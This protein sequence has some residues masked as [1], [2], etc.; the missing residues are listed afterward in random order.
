MVATPFTDAEPSRL[1]WV[2]QNGRDGNSGSA[3]APMRTIQ[4]AVDKAGPGTAVMVKAGRYVENVE[5]QGVQGTSQKPVWLISADGA[6]KAVIKAASNGRST[7]YAHGEDNIVVEG[8]RIEG[9]KN[10]IQFSQ[11][12]S[13]FKDL[14]QNLVVQGNTIVNA[15]ADG[16]KISQGNNVHIIDNTIAGAGDQGIDFVAVNGSVIARNVVSGITGSSGAIFAKGGSTGIDIVDNHVKS[17][18]ADGIV[19]GGWT[20]SAYFRPGTHGW[21]AR[22]VSVIGNLVEGVARRALNVLG[23]QDVEVTGNHFK[24]NPGYSAAVNVGSGSPYLSKRPVSKNVDIHDNIISNAKKMLIVESGNNNNIDFNR[25]EPGGSWTNKTGPGAANKAAAHEQA[26]KE[27]AEPAPAEEASVPVPDTARGQPAAGVL[28]GVSIPAGPWALSGAVQDVREG[29]SAG[30]RLAGTARNDEMIGHGGKDVLAGGEG[31]DLYIV[32]R[33]V[34]V[35]EDAGEGV[36]TIHL[37]TKHYPQLG[38]HIENVVIRLP[39]DVAIRGNALDNV[40]IGGKGGDTIE[41]AAGEDLLAGGAG[42]D[43]FVYGDVTHGGD[44]ILDFVPGEDR[45]DLTGLIATLDEAT[46]SLAARDGGTALIVTSGGAEHEL[47]LLAGHQPAD[48]APVGDLLV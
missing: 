44:L 8:F 12:G 36:D 34:T 17:S 1:I 7:V 48:L 30:Q 26:A 18:K 4:A 3:D 19:V 13:G 43:T 35:D 33:G 37:W 9:G 23:G 5:F 11:A 41:G 2:S 21:E 27:Q 47:A 29:S 38:E 14:T 40:I 31:D 24:A 39:E 28:E 6:E 46:V 32:S 15:R 42:R 22:D 20:E 10:G 16:V 45:L 25:N